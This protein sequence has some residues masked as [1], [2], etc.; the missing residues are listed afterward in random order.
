MLI[1]TNKTLIGLESL[2]GTPSDTAIPP[3]NVTDT[4]AGPTAEATVVGGVFMNFCRP[5]KRYSIGAVHVPV[6]Y[7]GH[8]SHSSILSRLVTL[9]IAIFVTGFSVFIIDRWAREK[10]V[11]LSSEVH[12]LG[13]LLIN[14]TA[15]HL[16][17][18]LFKQ[19]NLKI[20]IAD[21]ADIERINRKASLSLLGSRTGGCILETARVSTVAA[22]AF[23]EDKFYYGVNATEEDCFL[24][25]TTERFDR[26]RFE[27][28][29]NFCDLHANF[30]I[31]G[32]DE[33]EE[34]D[35]PDFPPRETYDKARRVFASSIGLGL[36]I[37][38]NDTTITD[39]PSERLDSCQTEHFDYDRWTVA[40]RWY[41][42]YTTALLTDGDE[43][44]IESI[45]STSNMVEF[46]EEV[47]FNIVVYPIVIEK[48]DIYM[49]MKKVNEEIIFDVLPTSYWE[50]FPK[51]AMQLGKYGAHSVSLTIN[52]SPTYRKIIL[53]PLSLLD[54]MTSIG[55]MLALCLV[56]RYILQC[57]NLRKLDRAMGSKGLDYNEYCRLLERVSELE[58]DCN[59]TEK[60]PSK[61]DQ[62][63]AHSE[64]TSE[65]I[66]LIYQPAN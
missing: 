40:I 5:F 4:G 30:R 12:D 57:Y 45:E 25:R 56:S 24:E 16:Q 50:K 49:N 18:K 33:R 63:V 17:Y 42:K 37:D 59:I 31:A 21:S 10:D 53:K 3:L 43:L 20:Y 60:E 23:E 11:M 62:F 38:P 35:V 27:R 32:D 64:P 36:R 55:G 9:L 22:Q 34:H 47:I 19:L 26:T 7:E 39:L 65:T 15:N 51:S 54:A 2:T 61:G 46:N 48:Y 29:Y 58:A 6:V 14:G 28:S 66:E 44:K 52:Y 8:R 1:F 41:I 13:G